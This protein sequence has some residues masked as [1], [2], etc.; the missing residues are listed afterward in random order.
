MTFQQAQYQMPQPT[1]AANGFALTAFILGLCAFIIGWMPL[2]G[3]LAGVAALVFGIL[4][5]KKHQTKW[6]GIVGIA[7]GGLAIVTSLA[8]SIAVGATLENNAQPEPKPIVEEPAESKPIEEPEPVEE[9]EEVQEEPAS[10]ALDETTAAQHLAYAWED[11]LPY[12]GSVHWIMDRITTENA[13][14]TYTFKIGATVINEYGTKVS[15]TVEGD[16]G[17]TT[18]NPVILDSILYLNTGE[19]I[20]YPR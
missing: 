3:L 4:A 7:C 12:G 5:L 13:D 11:L 15:G 14:G 18:E 20:E 16:V 17:G 1:R 8:V 19:I 2:F 9:V 10:P 6:M